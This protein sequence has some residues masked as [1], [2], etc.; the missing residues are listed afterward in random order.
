MW[1]LSLRGFFEETGF[2]LLNVLCPLRV[3]SEHT[4]NDFVAG[5]WDRH[6][7][8]DGKSRGKCQRGEVVTLVRTLWGITRSSEDNENDF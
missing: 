4:L 3:S 7:D 2:S 1:R 5:R 8:G 6:D